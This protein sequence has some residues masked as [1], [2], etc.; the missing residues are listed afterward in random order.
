MCLVLL[1]GACAIPFVYE[2]PS[3]FYKTGWDRVMLRAGK[4]FGIIAVVLIMIQPLYVS[5]IRWLERGFSLRKL[6]DRHRTG[7]VIILIAAMIHPLLVLAADH[8]V[9]FP[10]ES[11]YWP[12]FTGISLLVL[13]MIFVLISTLYKK[14]GIPYNIWRWIHRAGALAVFTGA[15]VHVV[16]VSRSFESG[17][18]LWGLLTLVGA[19]GVI[20]VFKYLKQ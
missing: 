17:P 20:L 1:I 5:R 4:I 2:S 14:L 8:F 11:R 18:P 10:F 15:V 6:L 16:N 9:F 13:L 12:E 19:A 7:G 3:L